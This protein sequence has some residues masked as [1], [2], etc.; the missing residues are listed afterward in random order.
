MANRINKTYNGISGRNLTKM[1]V[2][3]NEPISDRATDV[4]KAIVRN[5]ASRRSFTDGQTFVVS[6]TDTVSAKF[7]EKTRMSV[8][9]AVY[10]ALAKY[11]A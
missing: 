5:I 1:P 7:P 4:T 2:R 10:R 9:I 6:V 3:N 8:L 11:F